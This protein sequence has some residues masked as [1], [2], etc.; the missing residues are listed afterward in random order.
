V[1]GKEVVCL[2]T[3]QHDVCFNLSQV[4]TSLGVVSGW[5]T[6]LGVVLLLVVD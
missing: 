2:C 3:V 4:F 5:L 1:A 6:S